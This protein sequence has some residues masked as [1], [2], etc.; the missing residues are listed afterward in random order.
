MHSRE[1]S[2]QSFE[3]FLALDLAKLGLVTASC[4]MPASCNQSRVVRDIFLLH[5]LKACFFEETLIGS[6]RHEQKQADGAACRQF[7]V[8][9]GPRDHDW[10]GEDRPVTSAENA[11][12]FPEDSKA[13]GNMVHRIDTDN[14][15]EGLVV[16]G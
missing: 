16:E 12:P 13:I 2:L 7:V 6:R 9:H 5:E 1:E 15:V 10:I 8:G 11:A 4:C 14:R 3:A